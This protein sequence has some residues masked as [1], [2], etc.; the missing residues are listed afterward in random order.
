[1]LC[2]VFDAP[3]LKDPKKVATKAKPVQVKAAAAKAASSSATTSSAKPSKVAAS[4]SKDQPANQSKQSYGQAG[5]ED[6]HISSDGDDMPSLFSDA[7]DD[8]F[9]ED[10]DDD[11]VENFDCTITPLSRPAQRSANQ[12]S[13]PQPKPKSTATPAANKAPVPA[14]SKQ[15]SEPLFR[16]ESRGPLASLYQAT[17]VSVA[18]AAAETKA[19]A[20]MK[21]AFDKPKAAAPKASKSEAG[22]KSSSQGFK[23]MFAAPSKGKAVADE[24]AGVL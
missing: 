6:V 8:E 21:G 4:S 22:T 9:D 17:A 23:G 5:K 12:P 20:F 18:K 16:E 2:A 3:D 19:G 1:M 13:A 24:A 11:S 10:D 7:S 15:T 14:Q